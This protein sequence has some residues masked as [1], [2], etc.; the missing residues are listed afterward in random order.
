MTENIL[1]DAALAYAKMG[2]YVFPCRERPGKP[3]INS[4]GETITSL[5]KQP[6]VSKGLDAAS[7]EPSQIQSW[8]SMYP[9]AMIGINC[10][11]SGLFVID[12]DKKN[13]VDGIKNFKKLIP[14]ETPGCLHS[15]TPSGGSHL[16]FSGKGKSSSLKGFQTPSGSIQVASGG[17]GRYLNVSPLGIDTRGEGGYIIAPP[18]VIL[19]GKKSGAY[20]PVSAWNHQPVEVPAEFLEKLF[21]N[22][23]EYENKPLQSDEKGKLSYATLYFLTQGAPGGMRNDTLFKALADYAGCGYTKEESR[24]QVRP[25]AE[26]IG[27]SVSEFEQTLDHAFSKDRT[28]S[29]PASLQEKFSENRVYS[30]LISDEECDILENALLSCIIADNT[31][32]PKVLDIVTS[33]DFRA[34]KNESVFK[35]I[36]SLFLDGISVDPITLSSKG[37]P[38]EDVDKIINSYEIKVENATSYASVIKELSAFRKFQRLMNKGADMAKKGDRLSD[39]IESVEKE[40]ADVSIASGART[41]LLVDSR[42]A[43]NLVGERIKDI[44]SGK[45]AVLKTGFIKFDKDTG[46]L[47][48]GDL[49]MLTGEPGDGKSALALSLVHNVGITQKKPVVFFT[50]EMSIHETICRLICQIT[51]LEFK[52]AFRGELSS[53]EWEMYNNAVE[54]IS[55]SPITF[56]DSSSM[57]IPELRSK[58]RKLKEKGLVLAVIDQLE[59]MKGYLNQA[60]YLQFDAIGY[61]IKTVGKDFDIPFAVCHQLRVRHG[62]DKRPK[63]SDPQMSDMNQAGEKPA[64]VIWAIVHKRGDDGKIVATKIKVMKNR[65]A[66]KD[67][68]PVIF[69]GERMLFGNPTGQDAIDAEKFLSE[70]DDYGVLDAEPEYNKDDPDFLRGSL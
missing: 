63:D 34:K 23:K 9:N 27:L 70:K 17:E 22:K 11:K 14:Y 58:I 67:D 18:S 19:E 57:T 42:Q 66:P 46:G 35:I 2:W 33:S 25:V 32:I 61:D 50:L 44:H 39:I 10:G 16:V 21:P 20:V 54:V 62:G 65:N 29:I 5:E 69:I 38:V 51:G 53:D 40:L 48:P 60:K 30:G 49:L 68:F 41:T 55:N 15:I 13:D 52:K 3:Y 1:L 43:T 64:T 12:L 45:I 56:D 8:W 24:E 6:Y 31:N 28:P 26:R 4:D 37:I 47:L 59:Q 36:E 7:I